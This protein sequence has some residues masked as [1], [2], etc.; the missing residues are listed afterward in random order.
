MCYASVVMSVFVIIRNVE[1]Q[2]WL[3][4]A[5]LTVLTQ[6]WLISS[7]E[8]G[9]THGSAGEI[10]RYPEPVPGVVRTLSVESDHMTWILASDWSW[11]L[12]GHWHRDQPLPWHHPCQGRPTLPCSAQ[13]VSVIKIFYIPAQIII[14]DCGAGA[15]FSV[16][17]FYWVWVTIMSVT[18]SLS[19]SHNN[20]SHLF[21]G[22][23]C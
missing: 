10:P 14:A 16:A 13:I 2:Y 12:S 5:S 3:R 15:K 6:E 18:C 23:H 22:Q 9:V 21:P 20:V 8:S 17:D 11:V 1:R 7:A 4:P 19:L